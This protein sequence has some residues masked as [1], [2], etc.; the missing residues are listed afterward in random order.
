MLK[1]KI[2]IKNTKALKKSSKNNHMTKFSKSLSKS[3][4]SICLAS[5]LLVGT[6][7]AKFYSENP[8]IKANSLAVLVIDMQD[9]WLSDIDEKELAIELPYQAEVLDYCKDNN[10]PVFVI[11][12]KNCGPTTKYLKEKIDQ[13]PKKYYLTKNTQ[14]AFES[15]DLEQKL[16]TSRVET[17]ILMGVYSS[18][19]V[20]GTAKGALNSGFQIA[21]SKELIADEKYHGDGAIEWYERKGIYKNS[22]KDLLSLIEK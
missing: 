14:S 15:T 8:K 2:Q 20:K 7:C 11:E 1:T 4:V 5:T 6:G 13:L 16:K 22:Y 3:L 21:T 19:C 17:L 9:F 12:Y 18:A 10:I